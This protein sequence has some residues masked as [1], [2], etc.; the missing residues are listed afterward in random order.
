M[1]IEPSISPMSLVPA[2]VF[3]PLIF[4]AQ[5]ERARICHVAPMTEQSNNYHR[6]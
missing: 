4:I 6:R 2:S 5:G 1:R 3:T